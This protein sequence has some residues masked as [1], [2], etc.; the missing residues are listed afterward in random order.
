MARTS[1]AR[2]LT[3]PLKSK[4]AV[5]T[6][7]SRG[8]GFAIAEALAAAGS[9]LVITSRKSA[10]AE[11][12]AEE[13]AVHGV[14]V[15]P[16]QCDVRDEVAIARL[17]QA[18]KDDFGHIDVLVNNAG[19]SHAPFP[20]DSLSTEVWQE[21]LATNLTG[22][23]LCTRAAL[24]LLTKGSTIVNNISVAA[25][26]IFPNFA[27]YTVS[28]AA[29]LAFTNAL[30]EEVRAR[31]IR[32]LALV[33]GATDTDIWNQFWP[34][35]PRDKMVSPEDVAAV[36]VAALRVAPVGAVDEIRIGPTSGRL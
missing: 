11:S 8:I 4:V 13:L 10:D 21:T 35:A 15:L 9:D 31:G 1:K 26:Q 20:I 36:V 16:I 3:D 25:Y 7:A 2:S 29:L 28:K 27:A 30:R 19:H 22:T 34:D 5:I 14:R 33:P 18:V 17:F 32:V 24:P 6:G 23:F 12:A